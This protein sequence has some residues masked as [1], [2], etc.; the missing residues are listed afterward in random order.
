MLSQFISKPLENHWNAA[1]NVLRYLQ[2]IVGYGIIYTNSSDVRLARFEYSDRVGK[3]DDRRSITS[4]A[5]SLRF[6]VITWSSKK[7][8]TV[9]LFSVEEESYA[10]CAATCEV[11]WLRRLLQDVR[12]E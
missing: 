3:V 12:E 5:F 6:G 4:Y 2:G 9:S 1:K 10:M 11:V 7:Q 8:N